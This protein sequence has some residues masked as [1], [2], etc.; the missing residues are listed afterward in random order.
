MSRKRWRWIAAAAFAV[1]VQS[2]GGTLAGHW[3]ASPAHA[4]SAGPSAEPSPTTPGKAHGLLGEQKLREAQQKEYLRQHS[5]ATGKIRPDLEFKGVQ[6]M[7]RM[8]VAPSVGAHPAAPSS[9]PS[10][11]PAN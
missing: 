10:A 7:H 5:D 4:Q 11:A 9:A 1:A 2:S 3:S 6:H 8:S